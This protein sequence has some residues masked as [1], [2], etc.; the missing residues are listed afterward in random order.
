MYNSIYTAFLP[1][2]PGGTYFTGK[3]LQTEVE[4]VLDFLLHHVF[5]TGFPE[6]VGA[7]VFGWSRNF[8]P[9]PAPTPTLQYLKYFVFTGPKYDYKYDYDYDYDYEYDYYYDYE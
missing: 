2:L 4:Q 3:F 7:G 8:H 9:A 6:P 1:Y 5:Y